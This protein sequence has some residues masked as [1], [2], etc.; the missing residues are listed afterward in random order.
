MLLS[1]SRV[2]RDEGTPLQVRLRP[3]ERAAAEAMAARRCRPSD[4]R[5]HDGRRRPHGSLAA[6]IRWLIA[7]DVK[8][9]AAEL[10]A[11]RGTLTETPG[12]P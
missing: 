5:V 3:A 11:G 10:E 8:R 7:E 9:H 1:S 4:G 12:D 6:Y 2:M